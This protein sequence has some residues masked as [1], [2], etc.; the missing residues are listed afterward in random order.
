MTAMTL[1]KLLQ[2][3]ISPLRILVMCAGKS[4]ACVQPKVELKSGDQNWRVFLLG[5]TLRVMSAVGSPQNLV[6]DSI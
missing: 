4:G 6:I 3:P 5:M 1:R 2:P